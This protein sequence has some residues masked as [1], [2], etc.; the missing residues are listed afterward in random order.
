M[1]CILASMFVKSIPWMW[2]SSG[3]G[4]TPTF[5]ESMGEYDVTEDQMQHESSGTQAEN[6]CNGSHSLGK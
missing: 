2:I 5:Q 1:A 6:P 4:R 3:T